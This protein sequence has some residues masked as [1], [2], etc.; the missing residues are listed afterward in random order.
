MFN[1]YKS[2]CSVLQLQV[3]LQCVAVRQL[4]VLLQCVAVR[5]LQVL[6]QCVAVRYDAFLGVAVHVTRLVTAT[7]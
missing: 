7:K 5:Q 3:V 1:S 4:Q 6:L 2:C